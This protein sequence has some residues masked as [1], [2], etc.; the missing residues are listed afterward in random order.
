MEGCPITKGGIERDQVDKMGDSGHLISPPRPSL[1]R[2]G[3]VVE[4][5][6]GAD[7]LLV[8]V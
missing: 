1:R 7:T 8:V 6:E 3:R 5:E 2:G 4:E